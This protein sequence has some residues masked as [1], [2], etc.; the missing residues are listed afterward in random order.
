MSRCLFFFNDPATTE[1]YTL[2]LHDALPILPREGFDIPRRRLGDEARLR[3]RCGWLVR[4]RPG[5]VLRGSALLEG[6]GDG[7]GDDLLPDHCWNHVRSEVACPF[8]KPRRRLLD[9][10]APRLFLVRRYCILLIHVS[11]L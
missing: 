2:S 7:G 3:W 4:R 11:H 9:P 10:T 8:S 6:A 1:L 5:A